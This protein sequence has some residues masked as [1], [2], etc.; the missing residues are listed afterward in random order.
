MTEQGGSVS[1]ENEIVMWAANRPVWQQRALRQIASGA[2]EW[3]PS[4][5]A[6]DLV[7]GINPAGQP[8]SEA[9]LASGG[10]SRISV[11]LRS[12]TPLAHVNAL[13]DGQ[14][15]TVSPTGITVVYGDNGS[16]KSGYA[17]LV[18]QVVRARAREIVL[19]DV[20]EDLAGDTPSAVIAFDVDGTPYECTWPDETAQVLGQVSFYDADCGTAYITS[21]T[22]VT[23]RPSLLVVLDGLI[24][25]CDA[26][27]A[28]LDMKMSENVQAKAEL[29]AVTEGT[30]IH[31]FLA[32][33]SGTT[34]TKA[35]D[36]ALTVPVDVEEQIASLAS[37]EARLRASDPSR[38]R[39]RLTELGSSLST[40]RTHF[41]TLENRLGHGVLVKLE[42][43]RQKAVDHRTAAN[44]ASSASFESEPLTGVGSETWRAMWEAARQYSVTEAYAGRDFPAIEPGDR[45]V[46]C[47]QALSEDARERLHR[48]HRFM[49]DHTERLAKES[50]SALELLVEDI[51][52]AEP[53]PTI[54]ALALVTIATNNS[55]I[56]TEC[57]TAI[58]AFGL[59]RDALLRVA[60]GEDGE[61]PVTPEWP[62][63]A[64]RVASETAVMDASNIDE[65]GFNDQIKRLADERAELDGRRIANAARDDVSREVTRLAEQE[66][67]EAARRMTDTTGITR[68]STELA[69]DHVTT[70]V[71]DR[72]TRE[73]E[74]LRLERVTLQS[75]G[76]RKGQLMQR[77]GLLAA[78][79]DAAISSVLS[80]GEQTALG[81]AGFLTEVH[82]DET[83]SAIVLDDPVTSLD[84]IRRSHVA[85]R[86]CQ[87]ARDRQVIVFTHD[88]TLVADIARAA[89]AEA[90]EVT[91]RAIERHGDGSIG[92]CRDQHPWKAKDAKG[93]LAQLGVDVARIRSE[94]SAW[95]DTTYERE[96][97]DWAGRLSETWE[98]II[99]MDI[100]DR[101][102]DK[103]KSEV[104]PQM[105]RVL[106]KVTEDD[107]G[108]FQSSYSR[109]SEWA[110][111][112][113]KSLARNYVTPKVDELEKELALVQAWHDRVRKY[114]N[115]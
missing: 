75:Q 37:Q 32:G 77:P 3:L 101:L 55:N 79:Q 57:R 35:M 8:L 41:E 60:S 113:D 112:H 74:D 67:I 52:Q 61:M 68:K 49:Q 90:V 45:C 38:E 48:F 103:G 107:N 17:R 27:R 46:L 115:L 19:N 85:S 84:H 6:D 11:Q 76:G 29:P 15:L 51:G 34:T 4:A 13:R 73:S 56:A 70:I 104:R 86:L 65:G 97:A 91:E 111:R 106:A 110:R 81:L 23:Y 36:E 93:R 64:V 31:A 69:R 53:E 58:E 39:K 95:D 16:G 78:K 24:H 40:V 30:P 12:V 80:E 50:Q 105:F 26:V 9:D 42:E 98:R 62:L 114:D 10:S 108:E 1:L 44:L 83:K 47:Q 5:V 96:V 22:E 72:F 14:C 59:R 2:P 88:L 66:R 18:K 63:E 94:M 54:V 33:L 100:V 71:L 102:V 87:F 25:R 21:D 43:A 20:F 82:F 109:C 89:V 7:A 28:E 92:M 99:S